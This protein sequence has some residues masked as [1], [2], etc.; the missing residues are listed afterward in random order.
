MVRVPGRSVDAGRYN[1]EHGEQTE[2]KVD[3]ALGASD[4]L[5]NVQETGGAGK[6]QGNVSWHGLGSLQTNTRPA[7]K[8][9]QLD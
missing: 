4:S 7:S 6:Q 5:P 2:K 9:Y 3:A 8:N 1:T